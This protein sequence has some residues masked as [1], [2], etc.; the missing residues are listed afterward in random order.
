MMAVKR[1]QAYQK[2]LRTLESLEAVYRQQPGNRAALERYR[3][4]L[5]EDVAS[6]RQTAPVGPA[7]PGKANGA[8]TSGTGQSGVQP[9]EGPVT[10]SGIPPTPD[11]IEQRRK[12]TEEKTHL[13]AGPFDKADGHGQGKPKSLKGVSSTWIRAQCDQAEARLAELGKLLSDP[14]SD[15]KSVHEKLTQIRTA[16]ERISTPQPATGP[17][18]PKRG[19]T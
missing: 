8:T 2:V 16:V 10:P 4:A 12:A 15:L 18:A 5:R 19:Q 9:P 13:P 6:L 17:T 14:G 11:E 1:D 3:Q 7:A